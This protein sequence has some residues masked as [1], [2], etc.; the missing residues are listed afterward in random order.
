MD[1][2][3]SILCLLISR[4]SDS[5]WCEL[6]ANSEYPGSYVEFPLYMVDHI[7]DGCLF[8]LSMFGDCLGITPVPERRLTRFEIEKIHDEVSQV[9][10]GLDFDS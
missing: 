2:D 8:I 5:A 6:H 9:M 10:E 3:E 4:D 7:N 1:N